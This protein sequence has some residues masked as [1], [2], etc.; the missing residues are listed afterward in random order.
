MLVAVWQSQSILHIAQATYG[1]HHT[2]GKEAQRADAQETVRE[3]LV[4]QHVF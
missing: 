4:R 2:L 1:D 3:R